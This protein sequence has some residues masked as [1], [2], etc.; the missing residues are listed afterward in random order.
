MLQIQTKIV[1]KYDTIGIY[2]YF[3]LKKN[4]RDIF[5]AAIGRLVKD[6]NY[7]NRNA[8]CSFVAILQI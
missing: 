6:I 7:S 2:L 3:L 8:T 4:G 5:C 1:H